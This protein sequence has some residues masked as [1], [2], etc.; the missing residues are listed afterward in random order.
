MAY[1]S[2]NRTTS[3]TKVYK[4]DKN[5]RL[6]NRLSSDKKPLK[7][8]DDV[9]GLLL[10]DNEVFVENEPTD[11]KHI[12]TKQYVDG[13][14]LSLI[15]EDNMATDS[16]TRP[17]SQQSVKAYVDTGDVVKVASVTLD[18]SDMNSLNSTAITIVAAQ[19][20]NQV[21]VP[22]SGM[23]FIERDG[24]TA[25]ANSGADLFISW[26]GGTSS[27]NTIY[28]IRRFMVTESG[29]RVWHLQHYTGEAGQSLTAGDNQP[30]TVKLDSAITS[31]SIDSM[32][33]VISYFVYDNS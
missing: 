33:V 12:A 18:E 4:D 3:N 26:N 8:G 9:T 10:A 29:D 11:S 23:V 16:A 5:L 31:G 20:A 19:G 13:S 28:Y 17:P 24:S 25:Q 2:S 30:L 1:G 27:T 7:I 21:I 6:D 32:K 22:T 15:D 14:G